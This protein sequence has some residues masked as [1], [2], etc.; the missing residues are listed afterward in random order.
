MTRYSKYG[1]HKS[2][3]SAGPM[4]GIMY[5]IALLIIVLGA[6]AVVNIQFRIYQ[7]KYGQ[8]MTFL[9]YLLDPETSR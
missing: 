2:S 7:K 6:I 1:R 4:N 5:V 8:D 3:R 9:D